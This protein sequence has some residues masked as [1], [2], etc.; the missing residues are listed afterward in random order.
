MCD[1]CCSR[2][3]P[4][5]PAFGECAVEA[6]QNPGSMMAKL[7]ILI[8]KTRF[9]EKMFGIYVVDF[10]DKSGALSVATRG[11]SW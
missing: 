5:V 6:F 1:G 7:F 9:F 4:R 2:F 10:N 11:L 8:V 3:L